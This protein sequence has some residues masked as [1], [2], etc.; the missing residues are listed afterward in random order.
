MLPSPAIRC[1]L[2][3]SSSDGTPTFVEAN[4]ATAVIPFAQTFAPLGPLRANS[5][6]SRLIL[7]LPAVLGEI[8]THQ[9]QN[10][11]RMLE[12]DTAAA[13]AANETETDTS[14]VGEVDIGR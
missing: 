9:Q 3:C 7:G 10:S 6:S 2:V 4:H 12:K 8:Q 5:E 14:L 1:K 13:C 11:C